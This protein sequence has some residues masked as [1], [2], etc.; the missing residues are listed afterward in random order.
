MS[1]LWGCEVSGSVIPSQ[2]KG[3]VSLQAV[4]ALA[5]TNPAERGI[6]GY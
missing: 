5:P 2:M 3:D 1:V 4:E 6:Q